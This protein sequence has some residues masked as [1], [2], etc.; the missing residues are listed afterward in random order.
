MIIPLIIEQL[1]NR[2][3]CRSVEFWIQNKDETFSKYDTTANSYVN[4]KP[5]FIQ[6]SFDSNEDSLCFVNS[7]K[8]KYYD[9]ESILLIP[10]KL[11]EVK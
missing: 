9:E 8:M 3:H 4:T 6:Q 7:K 11:D 10:Y 2:F 5:G 1:Q